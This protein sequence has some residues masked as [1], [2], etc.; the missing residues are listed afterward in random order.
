MKSKREREVLSK[1]RQKLSQEITK[2]TNA[3]KSLEMKVL[4]STGEER[5]DLLSQISTLNS[6][7]HKF[8]DKLSSIRGTTVRQ[9]LAGWRG[10]SL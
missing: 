2:Y 10:N 5:I 7:T 1:E 4:L 8:Q 6:F 9:Q 3:A